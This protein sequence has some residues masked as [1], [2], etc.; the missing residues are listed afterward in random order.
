MI[1]LWFKKFI[2]LLDIIGLLYVTLFLLKKTF[3]NV[4]IRII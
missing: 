1:L 4:I 3:E 2:L